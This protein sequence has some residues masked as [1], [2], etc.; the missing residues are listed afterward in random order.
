MN[1]K[2]KLVQFYQQKIEKNEFENLIVFLCRRKTT[3]LNFETLKII[4]S[5][6]MKCSKL[7]I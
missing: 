5:F 4:S 2:V 7:R 1:Y 6:N 3:I